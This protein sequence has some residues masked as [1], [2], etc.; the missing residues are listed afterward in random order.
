MTQTNFNTTS[1]ETRSQVKKGNIGEDI[2]REFLEK[3]GCVCYKAKTEGP[4][5]FDFLASKGKSEIFIA[6]IKTKARL[7]RQPPQTGFNTKHLSEYRAISKKHNLDVFV[8]FVDEHPAEKRVYGAKLV[9]LERE[10]IIS[11]VKFPNTICNGSITVFPLAA[12][13][14]IKRL[15]DHQVSALNQLSTRSYQYA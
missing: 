3:R 9:E 13:I 14:P 15:E 2:V 11:G 6:E 5:V 12:M 7:N 10:R 8:F 1:W 4:H